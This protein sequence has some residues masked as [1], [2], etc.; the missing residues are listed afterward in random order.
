MENEIKSNGGL[1][2][3]QNEKGDT[4]VDVLFQ[5]GNIW[6]TQAAIAELYQTKPQNI[7]QHIKHIYEDGELDENRTCKNYLQVQTEGNRQI[8]RNTKHY[9]FEMILAIGYRVRTHVGIHFRNWATSL[10]H[11]YTQKGFVLNDERLKNPKPLGDDYFDELLERIK[12]IRASEQRFYEKVKAIYATSIDYDKDNEKTKLFFKTVQNKM[13]YSVH[14]HTAAEIINSRADATKDNMGLTS[15]KGAVV[16]KG[17]VDIAK[18]YLS[19][20]EIEA[21]N[22]IVVMYLDYAEDMAKQHIPMH[23]ADW[24]NKLNDF[25]KFYGRKI[26]DNAGSVT[27]EEAKNKAYA[28]YQKFNT[29]R[30]EK[31]KTDFAELESRVESLQ[32]KNK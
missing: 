4:K 32:G 3:Y 18:N 17:D 28:E 20:D 22:R 13:H 19:K 27:A 31:Q 10:I 9:S 12:D 11:E 29:A 15:W 25:L 5:N 6:M 26:L 2:I 24:E 7:T 8:K 30:I 21:L 14:S 23:M 16:R 1:M